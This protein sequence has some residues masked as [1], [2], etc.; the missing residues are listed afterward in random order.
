MDSSA[1][2][3]PAGRGTCS[4]LDR[5]L[6]DGFT[7]VDEEAVQGDLFLNVTAEKPGNVVDAFDGADDP[8]DGNAGREG[9]E[10]FAD[11]Y[12]ADGGPAFAQ[13][14]EIAEEVVEKLEM[15]FQLFAFAAAQG[16]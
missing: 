1:V 13:D 7:H 10:L 11:V 6:L 16:F 12:V 9:G 15:E 5:A 4:L 2:E 3:E 8:F 14:G